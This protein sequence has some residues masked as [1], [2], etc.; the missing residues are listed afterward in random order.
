[1]RVTDLL[2]AFTANAYFVVIIAVF[3]CRL[4]G[5]S[6]VARWIGL[7]SFLAVVPLVYLL[8]DA[9]RTNRP[10]MYFAWVGLAIVFLVGELVFDG[11]LQ[12]EF[13][14]VRW[15]TVTYVVVFFAATGGMIGITSQAGRWW[16][17]ATLVTFWAMA[18]L[19][20]V[21]RAK[22]GL[23]TPLGLAGGCWCPLAPTCETEGALE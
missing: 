3:A 21:Q 8:V 20:F 6:D 11:V 7:A 5:R 9:F 12:L 16:T 23:W 22:T 2:G 17:V 18:V 1:M 13:R 10:G 4:L 15:A 19:A 14:S